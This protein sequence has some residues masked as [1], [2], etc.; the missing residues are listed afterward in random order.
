MTVHLQASDP[1]A[2]VQTPPITLLNHRVTPGPAYAQNQS[3]GAAT[4][5]AGT[6]VAGRYGERGPATRN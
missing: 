3:D 1:A 4:M 6:G 5:I 2:V